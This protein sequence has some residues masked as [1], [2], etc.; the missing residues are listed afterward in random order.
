MTASTITLH[1]NLVFHILIYPPINFMIDPKRIKEA[2][3]IQICSQ[4][5][6]LLTL[7]NY[8]ILTTSSD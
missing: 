4:L 3:I 1:M 8:I 5:P 6:S 2:A 7:K